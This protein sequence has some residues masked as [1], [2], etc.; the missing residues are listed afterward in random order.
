[1]KFAIALGIL[2][3]IAVVASVAHQAANEAPAG[4]KIRKAAKSAGETSAFIVG[5]L[6]IAMFVQWLKHT[7]DP[8]PPCFTEEQC[9]DLHEMEMEH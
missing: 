9:A 6:A 7:I 2:F 1:M 4:H 5:M 8:S 3:C